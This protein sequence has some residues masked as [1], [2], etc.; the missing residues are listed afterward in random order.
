MAADAVGVFFLIDDAFRVVEYV[1]TGENRGNVEA[2]SL[3]S[4]R[5]RHHRGPLHTIPF[6]EL[7]AVTNYSLGWVI[8]KMELNVTFVDEEE[9]AEKEKKEEETVED[10][11]TDVKWSDWLVDEE[12]H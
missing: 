10:A 11:P 12:Y 1:E 9:E 3:R 4:L 7:Q 6:G 2:I 8:E 5:L